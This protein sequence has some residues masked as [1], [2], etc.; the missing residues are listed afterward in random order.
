MEYS[1]CSLYNVFAGHSVCS[2]GSK[3]FAGRHGILLSQSVQ[4]LQGTLF[5]VKDLKRLQVDM[6]Y[7]D[8][9]LYSVF[10]ALCL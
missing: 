6:E 10:R 4:R 7:S 8:R 1:D 9:S 3:A 5:V 2:Q